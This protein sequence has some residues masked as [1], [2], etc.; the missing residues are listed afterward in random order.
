[1]LKPPYFSTLH[2]GRGLCYSNYSP[3]PLQYFYIRQEGYVL[4]VVCVTVCNIPVSQ[5]VMNGV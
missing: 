3:K 1:M 4:L 2:R 5:K